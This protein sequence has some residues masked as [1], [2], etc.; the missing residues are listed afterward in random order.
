MTG[1]VS[2]HPAAQ[3]EIEIET[4]K[5]RGKRRSAFRFE[6][7]AIL[8]AIA[9]FAMFWFDKD[10]TSFASTIFI[11]CLGYGASLRGMDAYTAMKYNDGMEDWD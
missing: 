6:L 2:N 9:G 1:I 3:P 11:A 8:V 10:V 7:F 4:K 5:E